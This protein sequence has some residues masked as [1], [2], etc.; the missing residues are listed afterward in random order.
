M[1]GKDDTEKENIQ[2]MG[3]GRRF[4]LKISFIKFSSRS[5]YT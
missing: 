1:R 3:K 2:D 4:T 5:D